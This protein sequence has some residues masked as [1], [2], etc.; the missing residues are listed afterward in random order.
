MKK[1][2]SSPKGLKRTVGKGEI[3]CHEKF[4][5]FPQSFERTCTVDK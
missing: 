1:A 2:E 4:L 5:L 3:A